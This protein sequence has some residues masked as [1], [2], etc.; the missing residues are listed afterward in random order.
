MRYRIA[1]S[2]AVAVLGLGIV[3]AAAGPG[4]DP[5]P[6]AETIEVATPDTTIR[7]TAG[8]DP[9]GTYEVAS[10]VVEVELAGATV[11]ARISEPVGATGLRPGVVFV[12]GAGTGRFQEA[13]VQQLL[14]MFGGGA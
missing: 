2:S 3:G 9:V 7:G 13:F 5:V 11:E 4:W 8:T 1:V 10:T 12:H 6:F 14:G